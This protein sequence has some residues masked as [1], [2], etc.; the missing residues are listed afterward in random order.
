[1]VE[2]RDVI[3]NIFQNMDEWRHLPAYQLERRADIFFSTYLPGFLEHKFNNTVRGI[4][5]EFPVHKATIEPGHTTNGSYK[6]DYLVTF[7]D[8]DRVVF[9]ELKTDAASTRH[10][11]QEYLTRAQS[12]DMG[13]LFG[14][15][16]KIFD[17]TDHKDKYEH[18]FRLAEKAGLID[19]NKKVLRDKHDIQIVYL[20]PHAKDGDDKS[21]R[22]GFNEF[23]DYV[24]RFHDPI[25]Q[26]FA[27]S[28]RH[29]ADVKAGS[30]AVPEGV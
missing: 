26:R 2:Q 16:E 1:M 20:Q 25:S 22:I 23:A 14:G 4:I 17:A 5:P 12:A 13:K 9:L 18:F 21:M 27:H 28:L 29:W 3:G 19:A 24:A 6:I 30:V 11:Q 15:L 8:S 7:H 10:E